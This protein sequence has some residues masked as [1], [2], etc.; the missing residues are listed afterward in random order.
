MGAVVVGRA[1]EPYR[2]VLR[3]AKL[4]KPAAG[5]FPISISVAMLIAAASLAVTP[6]RAGDV[7]RGATLYG[8]HCS[9][10][11]GSGGRPVLPTAP[12]FTRQGALLKPDLALLASIR[13]GRGAMPAY[14]GV[15]RDSDILDI[16]TH[17]RT[18]R[19]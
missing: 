2:R 10:C 3:I 4:E 18:L 15:L 7:L 12:D 11:H 5:R 13:R 8:Q 19:R 1:G 6:A 16:V 17:L 9:S 14:E